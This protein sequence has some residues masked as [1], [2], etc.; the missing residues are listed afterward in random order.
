MPAHGVGFGGLI[1]LTIAAD[2]TDYNVFV[3][4]GSPST[5]VDVVLTINSGVIVYQTSANGALISQ[6]V[7]GF[8]T[9]STLKIVNNGT[10]CGKGGKGADGGAPSNGAASDGATGFDAIY[11]NTPALTVTIDNTNGYILGGGGGG[12]GGAANLNGGGGGG[13]GRGRVGGLGGSRGSVNAGDG[14]AGSFASAGVGGIADPAGFSKEGAD[15]GDWGQPGNDAAP[16]S[17]YGTPGRG[18]PAGWA[19]NK[20]ATSV[21]FVGGYNS[22]QVKGTVA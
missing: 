7:G 20:G 5:R 18:G 1:F 17:H 9:G 15:G 22:T 21:T 14:A 10:I 3:A 6:S 4:A 19:I 11:F 12:G 8:Q 16:V 13:G 2:T